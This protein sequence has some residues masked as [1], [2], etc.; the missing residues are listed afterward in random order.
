MQ[1]ALDRT[2]FFDLLDSAVDEAQR[3]GGPLALLVLDI[4]RFRDI[5]ST[6]GYDGG[7]RALAQVAKRVRAGLRDE[8]S[9]VRIGDDQFALILPGVM[10]TGHA[11]LAANKVTTLL[12]RPFEI[13]GFSLRVN[14]A[15]GIALYPEHATDPRALTGCAER[16]LEAAKAERQS[17]R[18]Y[19]TEPAAVPLVLEN[20]LRHGIENGELVLFYQPKVNLRTGVACG[21]EALVRWQRPRQGLV[22]PDEFIP[23]AEAGDLIGPLSL[24]TLNNALRQCTEHGQSWGDCSVSVNFSAHLLNDPQIVESVS[25]AL[26]VWHVDPT[27]LTVELTESAMMTEVGHGREAINRL[28]EQG[29]SIAVDD[30]GTGYSSLAYLKRL[31]VQE[32]KIDKSFVLNMADDRD[33]AAIVRSIVDLGHNFGLTVTAEGAE[34]RTSLDLL[35]LLGCDCAQGFYIAEPLTPESLEQWWAG[36]PW[37]PTKRGTRSE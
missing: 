28:H 23:I 8:D 16:A 21:A 14:A 32:L 24:W 1:T 26:R 10:N 17:Y 18:V 9:M 29:V 2:G 19:E 12:E 11:V 7:D 4:R 36:S 35:T 6:L 30:F 25:H 27:R 13:D 20:E 22:G 37:T 33:D 15:I 3:E 31:P 34:N 5:N